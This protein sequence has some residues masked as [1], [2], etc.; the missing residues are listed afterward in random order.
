M[1]SV[2]KIYF[3]KFKGETGVKMKQ[4]VFLVNSLVTWVNKLRFIINFVNVDISARL[5]HIPPPQKKKIVHEWIY[6][7]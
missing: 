1:L 3:C 2:W 5:F 6:L 4:F 7:L